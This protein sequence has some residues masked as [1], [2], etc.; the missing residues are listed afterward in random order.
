[1]PKGCLRLDTD[2]QRRDPKVQKRTQMASGSDTP[3]L[4]PLD[5]I[6]AQPCGGE[7]P[8]AT[9]SATI[10]IRST[11]GRSAVVQTAPAFVALRGRPR[12]TTVLLKSQPTT[13]AAVKPD[14]YASHQSAHTSPG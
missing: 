14:G 1:M 11:S 12:L 3:L 9:T 10:F 6:A 5:H 8:P 2:H 13:N 4:S 7:R